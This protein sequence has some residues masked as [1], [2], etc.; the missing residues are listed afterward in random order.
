LLGFD[1][2]YEEEGFERVKNDRFKVRMKSDIV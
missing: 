2:R 1:D